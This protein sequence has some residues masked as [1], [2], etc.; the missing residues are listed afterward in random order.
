[1]QS[2]QPSTEVAATIAAAPAP[3]A[4]KPVAKTKSAPAVATPSATPP[5]K[6][7]K[8]NK[9]APKAASKAET[10]APVAAKPTPKPAPKAAAKPATKPAAVADAAKVAKTKKIKMVRDSI[11]IPKEE[12]ALIDLMKVRAGK[13]G[14]GVKKTEL[15]RAGIK[16]LAALPNPAFLAAIAAVPSLKT[17]R[18]AKSA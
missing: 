9:A 17:G 15:L 12:Y 5:T 1:M 16:V 18:P 2:T 14:T 13:L 3:Q 6:V 7:T 4:A 10:K 8:A 11:S